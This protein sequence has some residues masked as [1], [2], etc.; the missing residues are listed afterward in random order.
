[1]KKTTFKK[2]TKSLRGFQ[3]P[4]FGVSWQPPELDSDVVR[5][6]ITF[7]EDRRVLYNPYE[8]EDSRWVIRS[9]LEI[10]Q[11]LTDTINMLDDNP[12]ICPHLRAMRAACRK[13]LDETKRLGGPG[14]WFHDPWGFITLGEL[15]GV[16]GLHIAQLCVMYGIDVEG[17]L[18]TIVPVEDRGK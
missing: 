5:N 14:R 2:M 1:M 17:E 4:V 15:R 18:G 11:R 10:R 3:T 12:H 7:L 8:L 9:V 6:L 16:F 13:F